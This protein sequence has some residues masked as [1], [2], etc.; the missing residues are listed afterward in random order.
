MNAIRISDRAQ[1]EFSWHPV[2]RQLPQRP[3]LQDRI[4]AEP[5]PDRIRCPF[6]PRT[7]ACVG[8]QQVAL[9]IGPLVGPVQPTDPDSQQPVRP[10]IPH[11]IKQPPRHPVDRVGLLRRVAQAASKRLFAKGASLWLVAEGM[12]SG[13][14]GRGFGQKRG[15][16][17]GGFLAVPGVG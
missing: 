1:P 9:R 12:S 6:C 10:L 5:C 8:V 13:P 2:W 16:P 14:T 17:V 3:P 11:R 7:F 15:N 4:L